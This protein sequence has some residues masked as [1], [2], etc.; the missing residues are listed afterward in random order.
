MTH[1]DMIVGSTALI[2]VLL[3]SGITYYW[4]QE[5]K[6]PEAATETGMPSL[7][8]RLSSNANDGFI[9]AGLNR[10]TGVLVPQ[11]STS[12]LRADNSSEL[13]KDSVSAGVTPTL[14]DVHFDF[15]RGG[16]PEEAKAILRSHAEILRNSDWSVLIQGHT[17]DRGPIKH[18]LRLGLRR[19]EKVKEYLVSLGISPS[20]IE[21]VSLGEFEPVCGE[22]LETCRRQNRRVHFSLA[23]LDRLTRSNLD[24]PP[25]QGTQDEEL[26]THIESSTTEASAPENRETAPSTYAAQESAV[27]Q[28]V[29][30]P[31]ATALSKESHADDPHPAVRESAEE[32]SETLSQS[33]RD[34]QHSDE[35][36]PLDPR[37][38]SPQ[39]VMPT[40]TVGT[41][42]FPI[43]D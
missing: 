9:K 7:E 25:Q 38:P 23:R 4:L 3:V 34:M 43:P 41:Q 42:F 2:G 24:I 28:P 10:G 35:P 40:E 31:H 16:L 30:I 6:Q 15:D 18:N 20:Q 8:M 11:D 13:P 26:S 39:S 32:Q 17:D 27:A 36:P 12:S 37:M 19:A 22:P 21:T 29:E 14:A 33:L 5:P 1:T